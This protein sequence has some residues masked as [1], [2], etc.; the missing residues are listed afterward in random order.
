MHT[1]LFAAAGLAL[2]VSVAGFLPRA[3]TTPVTSAP[4]IADAQ[5]ETVKHNGS[6]NEDLPEGTLGDLFQILADSGDARLFVHWGVLENNIGLAEET[7]VPAIPSKGLQHSKV[8]QLLNS[9]L[10]LQGADQIDARFDDGLL[11]IATRE[12]FDRIETITMDHDV[13]VIVPS[14]HVLRT[15]NEGL[16]LVASIQSIVEPDCWEENGG[17]SSI[18]I[19]GSLLS[20]RAPE[21]IQKEVIDFIA[22]LEAAQRKQEADRQARE[23]KELEDERH[24]FQLMLRKSYESKNGLLYEIGNLQH[25]LEESYVESWKCEYGLKDLEQDYR[26]EIDPEAKAAKLDVLAQAGAKLDS[27]RS[28]QD[29]LRDQIK[30]KRSSVTLLENNMN[31]MEWA[32][33]GQEDSGR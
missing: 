11:E 27:L 16:S 32:A 9:V 4:L 19:N 31:S 2:T 26:N 20:V 18:T 1:A 28:R 13:S 30:A 5:P 23:K 7:E 22:R 33:A 15:T 14:D 12:Y 6:L 3:S 17:M 25:E 8:K 29:L 24:S 10:N 21:R